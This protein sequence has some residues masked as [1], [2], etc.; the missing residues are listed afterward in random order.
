MPL[1][2]NI[3][4]RHVIQAT[5]SRTDAIAAV[6][7]VAQ[8]IL[9]FEV[10][11][12]APLMSIGIDSL[13]ASEFVNVLSAQ[14]GTEISETDLFDH[15]TLNSIA[16]YAT[17]QLSGSKVAVPLLKKRPRRLVEDQGALIIARSFELPRSVSTNALLRQLSL[18]AHTTN[19]HVPTSRWAID[20]TKNVSASY[21]SFM[22]DE[23]LLFDHAAFGISALEARSMDPQ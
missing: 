2:S 17:E 8:E 7:L 6:R 18:Q 16:T 4:N 11:M 1:W 21:G 19:S 23:Q 22:S 12:D 5:E 13:Q 10:D 15:P 3:Q 20:T 9:G 14:L